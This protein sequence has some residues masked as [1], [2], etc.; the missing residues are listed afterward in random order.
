MII[1]LRVLLR[2]VRGRCMTCYQDPCI[3]GINCP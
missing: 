3:R 1:R 2:P